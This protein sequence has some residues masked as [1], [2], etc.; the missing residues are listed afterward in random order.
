MALQG[1]HA[2]Q[3]MDDGRITGV[4]SSFHDD[5]RRVQAPV[6]CATSTHPC[7]EPSAGRPQRCPLCRSELVE[8][9]DWRHVDASTWRLELSCPDCGTV[10]TVCLDR[11]ETHAFNVLL[12]RSSEQL[13]RAAEELSREC[14]AI[15]EEDGRAFAA[16]LRGDLILPMDF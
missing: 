15:D 5:A 6:G 11:A 16:A 8:P 3:R 12:Y 13:A 1:D 2:R 4:T 9:T 14:A 7:G 10:R